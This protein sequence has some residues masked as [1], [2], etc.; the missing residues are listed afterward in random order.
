MSFYSILN[1]NLNVEKKITCVLNAVAKWYLKVNEAFFNIFLKNLRNLNRSISIT[2]QL[3]GASFITRM[4]LLSFNSFWY[5][6]KM[7]ILRSKN[8]L[9]TL[10]HIFYILN[11][12]FKR[13]TNKC[14]MNMVWALLGKGMFPPASSMCEKCRSSHSDLF[15]KIRTPEK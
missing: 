11:I 14:S 2:I 3:W 5:Y 15:L 12:F 4:R 7:Y 1:V 10:C 8:F 9:S 6:N 13:D